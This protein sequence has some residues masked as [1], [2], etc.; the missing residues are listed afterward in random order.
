MYLNSPLPSRALMVGVFLGV[1]TN[2]GDI[3]DN[4]GIPRS[5]RPY[6][7]LLASPIAIY[8]LA[9]KAAI[10]RQISA[11]E[12]S[13]ARLEELRVAVA[14]SHHVLLEEVKWLDQED[15]DGVDFRRIRIQNWEI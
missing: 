6:I 3:A 8:Y 4:V 5:L 9:T 10:E 14:S 12:A 13:R 1:I 2:I 11:V 15:W 7:P